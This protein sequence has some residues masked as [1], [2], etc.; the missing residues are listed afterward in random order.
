[1]ET[2]T[3]LRLPLGGVDPLSGR[4]VLQLAAASRSM[5]RSQDMGRLQELGG[6]EGQWA[7]AAGTAGGAQSRDLFAGIDTRLAAIAAPL[8]DSAEREAVTAALT[9]AGDL[10]ISTRA[11]LNAGKLEDA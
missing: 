1:D 7:W 2:S 10:A 6:Q 11:T 8:T 5:H 4:S 3:T 9:A